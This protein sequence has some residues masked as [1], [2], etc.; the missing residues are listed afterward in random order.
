MSLFC[1]SILI[2]HISLRLVGLN[3]YFLYC[4][5][6]AKKGLKKRVY[7]NGGVFLLWDFMKAV[8]K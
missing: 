3:N 2:L 8:I 7:G 5:S 1:I 4:L 6:L